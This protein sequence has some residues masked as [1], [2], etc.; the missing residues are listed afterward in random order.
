MAPFGVVIQLTLAVASLSLIHGATKR[1]R[2][3]ILVWIISY[4]LA[5]LGLLAF[6]VYSAVAEQNGLYA[7]AIVIA[8]I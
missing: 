5:L 3:F 6:E 2:S 8:G 1:K 4:T 7:I